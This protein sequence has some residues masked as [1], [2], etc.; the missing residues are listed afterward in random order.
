MLLLLLLLLLLPLSLNKM[1]H[2][3][4]IPLLV[5]EGSFSFAATPSV[6]GKSASV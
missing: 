4:R 3:I 6:K 5:L 1:I 2:I